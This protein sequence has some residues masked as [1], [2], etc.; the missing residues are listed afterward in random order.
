MIAESIIP[1]GYEK[2][3]YTIGLSSSFGFLVGYM[4]FHLSF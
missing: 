3:R 1:E 4:L 2:A